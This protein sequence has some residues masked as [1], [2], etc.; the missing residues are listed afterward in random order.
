MRILIL[1]N[2]HL[3]ANVALQKF[4][5]KYHQNIAGLILPEFIIPGKSFLDSTLFLLKKS[6]FRFVFYKWLEVKIYQLKLALG[7][8]QLKQFAYYSKKFN[9]PLLK[10]SSVN[11]E[12]TITVIKKLNPDV[13]YSVA[14]PQ[15]ISASVLKIPPNGCIN[16]HDSILPKYRGLCA[17]FWITAHN[18][19]KG[20]VTAIYIDKQLDTGKII[21]QRD[22]PIGKNDTMQKVY[23]NNAKLMA[24]MIFAVQDKL[25]KNQ[26]RAYK[27]KKAGESYYSWPNKEGYALFKKYRK[28]FFRFNELWGSI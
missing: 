12:T 3:Y 23:F 20:G 17:Y 24:E 9:F 22:Y 7:L 8:G 11:S 28:R 16:F 4:L 26:V 19:P 10:V 25:D 14:F 13:I 5:R 15:K 1:A 27:Q 6:F 18:E 2:N 21:M